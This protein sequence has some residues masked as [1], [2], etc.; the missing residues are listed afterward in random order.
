VEQLFISTSLIIAL[1]AFM[2]T[3]C[4]R[5]VNMRPS[6]SEPL[7]SGEIILGEEV[8]SFSSATIY[9]RLED[10]SLVDAFSKTV[11]EQVLHNIS[12]QAG[13][14]SRLAIDLRGTISNE[15][16][17]YAVR[18]HVDVDGDGQVSHGDYIS[19]EGYPVLTFGYPDRVTVRVR[20]VK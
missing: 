9:V 2:L 14:Q 5:N 19:M 15:R 10:V 12:H 7:V 8:Q 3:A 16:A 17:R 11:A 18:V 1:E 20:E 13:Y 6:T 4:S